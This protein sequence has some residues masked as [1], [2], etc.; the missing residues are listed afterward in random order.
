MNDRLSKLP[1]IEIDSRLG[2]DREWIDHLRILAELPYPSLALMPSIL[3]LVRRRVP[4]A[5][6]GFGW[7]DLNFS[8]LAFMTEHMHLRAYRWWAT[9][10]D[11]AFRMFPIRE[12]W[13]S[14]GESARL[15]CLAPE[16]EDTE[17]CQEV[18]ISQGVRWITIAPVAIADG[19]RLGF[20]S[21]YRE[22]EAG[23]YTSEEQARLLRGTDAL[24]AL[25]RPDNP[26]AT[27][28]ASSL[29]EAAETSLL[30]Q[31]D[32]SMVARSQEAARLIYL[33]GGA[34]MHTLEWARPDW[35]ALPAPVR[36]AAQWL[37]E[38]PD[39]EGQRR[40]RIDQPWGRFEFTLEKMVHHQQAERPL[41]TVGLRYFE[42]VDITV[43][44]RLAGWP[45]TPREKTILI[46][47]TR[48]SNLAQL[49]GVLGISINTL[50]TYNKELVDRIG[51]GSRTALIDLLLGDEAAQFDS[52]HRLGNR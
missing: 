50:K 39:R 42:A 8:P 23:P 20:L 43:A 37:F 36:D 21:L 19:H 32:G 11:V 31:E 33:L 46:A 38:H 44:R 35:L 47:S 15:G 13:E 22:P 2:S 3:P 5:L 52:C 9:N 49:A 30:L 1:G 26:L 34:N 27:L 41:V 29:K 28:P 16:F 10:L 4:S 25:D 7:A 40:V 45:L 6:A 14:R 17:F 24:A 51:L 12:Q 48:S 18:F